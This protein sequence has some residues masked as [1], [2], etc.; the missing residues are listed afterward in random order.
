MSKAPV[1]RKQIAPEW[2]KLDNAAKIYP[3]TRSSEWMAVYR[4]SVTLD[5]VID[6]TILNQAIKNTIKRLPY[7][8]YRLR[9]G[10]FWYYLERQE[11]YPLAQQDAANPCL[12]FNR[13]RDGHFVMRVR[14]HDKRIALEVFHVLADGTGSFTFLMTLTAE[15]LRIKTGQ[16][17]PAFA[18]YV[19]DCRDKPKLPEYEDSFPIYARKAARPRME[20]AAY[21]LR[22]TPAEKDYLQVTTAIMDTQHLK[23]AAKRHNVT[24]NTYL[25]AF[26][27]QAMLEIAKKDKNKR[28]SAKPVKLSM[29]VNLRKYYP[30][31]TLR[32]FSSYINTPIY[33]S[34]GDYTFDEIISLIDHY[35]GYELNE[36]MINARF[37]A[38]VLAEQSKAIR[39]VPWVI[40]GLMLKVMYVLVGE[41]YFSN[42]F[43]NLGNIPLP[44]GMKEHITRMDVIVG[45]A[46]S[47]P[48][49]TACVSVNGKT[50]LNFSKT[51]K[52]TAFEQS[53]LTGLVREGVHVTVESNRRNIT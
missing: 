30:S 16:R 25:A 50:F 12:P 38:N 6:E 33:A 43:T 18:P 5:E 47:N 22:G 8:A 1:K 4:L 51:I 39:P 42:V 27:M 52:E 14:V 40:K 37:S 11:G 36:K 31:Q 7:F 45:A 3:A 21:P 29:P 49:S 35:M 2:L 20:T 28:R 17:V 26:I 46:H 48:I 10:V 13:K 19:L 15:Y 23:N 32:N 44:Q 41:R 9:R 24:I 53:V 34:Y